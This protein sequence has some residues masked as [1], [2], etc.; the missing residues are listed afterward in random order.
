MAN[1][2]KVAAVPQGTGVIYSPIS[3]FI[4]RVVALQIKEK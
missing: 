3:C 4:P 1:T 2:E